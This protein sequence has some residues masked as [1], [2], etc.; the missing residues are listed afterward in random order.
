MS[1]RVISNIISQEEISPKHFRMV[2]DAPEVAKDAQMGQFIHLKW[3]SEL[4]QQDP[5]LRRPISLNEID[6]KS[7]AITIIYRVI[8]RGTQLLSTLKS[9][10]QVDIMGPIGMGFSIPEDSNKLIIVGGGMGIAPLYPVVKELVALDKEVTVLIGAENKG[11]L[12]NLED[13]ETMNVEL[14]ASTVDGSYGYQGFVTDFL[15][16]N[17]ADIDYI[18]TCGPEVMMEVVQ[19]WATEN[20]IKGETSLEERMGCG[21]GACLSCVCKIKVRNESGWDYKKTCIQGPVF[22]LS[23]VIFDD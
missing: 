18:Y 9:G 12:L 21:T 16:D 11:Q 15:D 10:D 13:Y 23:E 5:I 2:I 17:L 22:P 8:G 1:K 7:G 19:R 3:T 14:K 6:K 20:D 4:N